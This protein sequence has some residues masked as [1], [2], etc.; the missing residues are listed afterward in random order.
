MYDLTFVHS[1]LKH[2]QASMHRTPGKILEAAQNYN[3]LSPTYNDSV[4]YY[5]LF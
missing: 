5:D 1:K 2:W 3:L 4:I